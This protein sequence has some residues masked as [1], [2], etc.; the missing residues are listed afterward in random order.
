MTKTG[1]IKENTT[2]PR[3]ERSIR[4]FKERV[5]VLLGGPAVQESTEA[6]GRREPRGHDRLAK[7]ISPCRRHFKHTEPC[8]HS[9]GKSETR[10]QTVENY[11]RGLL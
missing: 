2:L 9:I 5:R 1:K 8:G 3:I 11:F 6:H 10:L 4:T 7:C